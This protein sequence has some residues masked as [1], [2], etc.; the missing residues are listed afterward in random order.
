MVERAIGENANLPILKSVLIK[1][2]Q[3]KIV[4]TSTNLELAVECVVPGKIIERGETAIPFPFFNSIIKNLNTERVTLE[5]K[6]GKMIMSTDNYEAVIQSQNSKEFPIIPPINRENRSLKIN[7]L[8]LKNAL[9]NVVVAAQYS[10][11]RPEI[12]GVYLN[13]LEGILTLAATDG[14]RLAERKTKISSDESASSEIS[15][16]IPLKAATEVMRIFGDDQELDIIIDAN[17]I[18][19]SAPNKKIISRL[20]D[21][22]FPDYRAIIPK[23]FQNE[24]ITDRNELIN[25]LKLASAFAGRANDVTLRVGES[26]K[27]FEVYSADS[28]VGENLY[29][30]P[31]KLKGDKVSLVFNWRYVLDGLKIC[32]SNE[33]SMG[34]N[35]S[36]RP[37][38]IRDPKDP[39]L[40]Y[41]A[42]PIKS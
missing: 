36:D 41:V 35:S 28:A 6:S 2:D 38:A 40:I 27:I 22:V 15:V 39:G 25:A 19:I 24:I 13:Y 30:V 33:I 7:S 12:S 14:F 18:L 29:R 10:D 23:S 26:S 34:V 20:I 17:Q 42:M 1:A 8:T 11:L 21:G 5:E 9:E 37:V 3:N 31:I 4:L 32:E 16:I